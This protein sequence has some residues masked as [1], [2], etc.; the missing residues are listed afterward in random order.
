MQYVGL[1]VHKKF[2]YASVL[3]EKGNVVM[4][5]KFQSTIES[6]DNFLDKIRNDAEFV[7]EASSVWQHLYDHLEYSGFT[8]KLAHPLKTRVIA[9]ARIKTDAIDAKTLAQLLRADLISESYVPIMDV[10]IERSITRHRASLVRM[11]TQIKN[12]IHAIL[13]RH[14]VQY[15]FSDLFGR[16]GIEFLKTIDIPAYSRYELDHYLTLLRV[17]NY[18]I[19]ESSVQIEALKK[20][21]PQAGLLTT[22]PGISD[23]SALL[24]M[25]EICDIRRFKTA[26]H[27]CSYAG[28]VPS[29]Y[30]SGNTSYH[31][32]ITKQGSKWLRW[33]LIQ[34]ANKAIL[35]ENALQRF[36][37]RLEAK[38]GRKI[39]IVAT[40]RKM[41]TYIHAMLT[42][43][44]KFDELQVNRDRATRTFINQNGC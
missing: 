33:I 10:R 23:Y 16:S 38:K 28:L 15:E 14:G 4:E 8:I 1:D 43:N 17:F 9:E 32:K 37:K 7:M 40:A 19:E 22:I 5:E 18:K 42:L 6:L 36:Y 20:D 12:K 35:K 41:L 11:R 24:I 29:T 25:A 21:N 27:L 13:R 34:A 31:G 26:E 39:A 3:D 30:Q 2:T 44:L